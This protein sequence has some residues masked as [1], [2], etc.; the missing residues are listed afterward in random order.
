MVAVC[1]VQ[2]RGRG[3]ERWLFFPCL[4]PSPHSLPTQPALSPLTQDATET[5]EGQS[6]TDSQLPTEEKVHD[7]LV[8]ILTGTEDRCDPAWVGPTWSADH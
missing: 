7:Q 6:A 5:P 1:F 8:I 2:F 4:S 3:G